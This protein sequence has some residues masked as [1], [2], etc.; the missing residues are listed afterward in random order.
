MSPR[1]QKARRPGM[2][3]AGPALILSALVHCTAHSDSLCALSMWLFQRPSGAS[4]GCKKG[5]II[6]NNLHLFKGNVKHF[7]AGL[8]LFLCCLSCLSCQKAF[9]ASRS[10]GSI[11]LGAV[12]PVPPGLQALITDTICNLLKIEAAELSLGPDSGDRP[13]P[14]ST[15]CPGFVVW[16]GTQAPSTEEECSGSEHAESSSLQEVY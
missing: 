2:G 5:K 1:R 16:E 12:C 11:P 7:A 6:W 15:W 4:R 13:F 9:P 3:A 8:L 14:L 10:S